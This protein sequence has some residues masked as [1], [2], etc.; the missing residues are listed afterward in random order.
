MEET[1]AQHCIASWHE[2]ELDGDRAFKSR[3]TISFSVN[4]DFLSAQSGESSIASTAAI[5]VSKNPKQETN[6]YPYIDVFVI[7]FH[8]QRRQGGSVCAFRHHTGV[9][10]AI[11]VCATL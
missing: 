7:A 8:E 11:V 1:L 6:N 5:G 10:C 3:N 4:L 2:L 9:S